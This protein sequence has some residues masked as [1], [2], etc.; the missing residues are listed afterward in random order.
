MSGTNSDKTNI[1]QEVLVKRLGSRVDR[2]INNSDIS[3]ML[4]EWC[5]TL[6]MILR[7]DELLGVLNDQK[8]VLGEEDLDALNQHLVN[9]ENLSVNHSH[10]PDD[11]EEVVRNLLNYLRQILSHSS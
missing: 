11:Y 2:F 8:V 4:G 7:I 9:L 1:S 5:A 6:S 10:S 3:E